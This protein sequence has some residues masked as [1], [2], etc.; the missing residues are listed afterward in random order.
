LPYQSDI[1]DFSTSEKS[2]SENAFHFNANLYDP[3]SNQES[4]GNKELTAKIESLDQY[5]RLVVRFSEPVLNVNVNS[6]AF[7]IYLKPW[8]NW[9]LDTEN[10]EVY[11]NLNLTW[12]F[13]S[14]DNNLLVL[15]LTF[16]RPEQISPKSA[17]DTLLLHFLTPEQFI[18]SE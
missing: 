18:S 1:S 13:S 6:S 2:S 8:N 11:P 10:Y 4:S 3:K 7:L 17:H 12:N 14:L 15:N 9:H 5:G 16:L